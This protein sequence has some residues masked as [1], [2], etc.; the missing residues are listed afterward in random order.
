MYKATQDAQ[1]LQRREGSFSTVPSARGVNLLGWEE[2][3]SLTPAEQRKAIGRRVGQIQAFLGAHKD[4]DKKL[5]W[6]LI[7]EM[8]KLVEQMRKLKPGARVIAKDVPQHFMEVARGRLTKPEFEIWLR[9]A[10]ERARAAD[11]VG[12]ANEK[13]KEQK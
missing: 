4:I 2:P 12:L 3:E 8:S 7:K 5:K 9:E 10:R 1:H 6:K 11:G 13:T